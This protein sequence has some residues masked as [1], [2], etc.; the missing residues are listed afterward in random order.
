VRLPRWATWTAIA[1]SI[2]A[3]IAGLGFW[4][5]RWPV[6]TARDFAEQV[7]AGK[8]TMLG[9]LIPEWPSD[10]C[11]EECFRAVN[12][13]NRTVKIM[14]R[15]WPDIT[16][17]RVRFQVGNVWVPFVAERG[18]VQTSDRAKLFGAVSM[19]Y[20]V[21]YN[22]QRIEGLQRERDRIEAQSP[23]DQR[24]IEL[25]RQAN[26]ISSMVVALQRRIDEKRKADELSP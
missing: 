23:S 10:R 16:G 17:G 24:A 9:D 20:S 1:I 6:E 25:D 7:A 2:L 22:T 8:P 12:D 26:E 11:F 13:D 21:I 14:P 19:R 15:S 4:W 18:T 3:P 5:A